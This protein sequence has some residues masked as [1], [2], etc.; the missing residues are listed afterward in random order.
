M[1]IL[2]TIKARISEIPVSERDMIPFINRE[3]IKTLKTMRERINEVAESG[4]DVIVDLSTWAGV[5]TTTTLTETLDTIYTAIA[6]LGST[7]AS[8]TTTMVSDL[9]TY[10]GAT[11]TD[12]LNTIYTSI[13]SINSSISTINTS[14]TSI[15]S[16]ITSINSSI[17]SINSSITSINSSITTL[18]G[19]TVG[20]KSAITLSSSRTAALTDAGCLLVVT[21]SA[22]LTLPQ[23]SD[24]AFTSSPPTVIG[25]V[26]TGSGA[27]LTGLA[28]TGATLNQA[29]SLTSRVRYA[30]GTFTKYAANTWVMNGDTT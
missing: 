26:V 17:T 20:W 5:S 8:I 7:V 15:N 3:L 19:Y 27:T 12:T 29:S 4:T 16:S 2:Q 25:W 18:T 21:A 28:G 30:S 24:V 13:A 10:A 6:A 23:D 1:A 14:I 11:L 9:S 22:T